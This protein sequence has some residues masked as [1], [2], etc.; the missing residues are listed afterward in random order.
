MSLKIQ[1]P[2]LISSKTTDEPVAPSGFGEIFASGSKLYFR[3]DTGSG[4]TVSQNLTRSGS[5]FTIYEYTSSG[6]WI[7][8]NNVSEIYVLCMGGGGGGGSGRVSAPNTGSS[9]GAGG[10]GGTIASRRIKVNALTA[11][12]YSITV[13]TG[14][15]GGASQTTNSTNGLNGSTGTASSFA[16]SGSTILVNA[17]GGGLGGGGIGGTVNAQ[18]N[19]TTVLAGNNTPAGYPYSLGSG[20]G[21]AAAINTAGTTI[22]GF[23][24][25]TNANVESGNAPGGGGGGVQLIVPNTPTN[26]GVNSGVMIA[27]T[28]I[29]S[30]SGLFRG[31]TGSVDCPSVV[32]VGSNIKRDLLYYVTANLTTY[33]A[34]LGGGGGAGSTGSNAGSGSNGGNYSAGGGG[35][36][37]ARNGFSSGPGGKGGDGLVYIVEYY[38]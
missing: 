20:V 14:G 23:V 8:P 36:G 10:G 34:G 7:K 17:V 24:G 4:V 16:V 33:G 30:G 12:S 9:G 1:T 19:G 22:N 13:G 29:V 11:T 35:G 25:T 5:S 21:T 31:T 6:F 2:L 3:S 27:S 32:S 37:G 26:G 38:Y 28:G 15:A 18:A